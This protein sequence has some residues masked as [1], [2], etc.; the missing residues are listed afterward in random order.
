MTPG[1]DWEIASALDAIRDE[2]IAAGFAGHPAAMILPYFEPMG[3][4]PHSQREFW[5]E[6]EW[7]MRGHFTFGLD[8]IVSWIVPHAEQ[9]EFVETMSER[10][11][12]SPCRCI[13]ASWSLEEIIAKLTDQSPI[14]PFE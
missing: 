8:Q 1:R 9:E 11:P 5:W 12:G 4:W 14:S 6:R 13:D 3:T 7:R 10:Y 2:A